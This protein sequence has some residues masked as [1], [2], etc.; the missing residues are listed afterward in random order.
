MIYKY[1]FNAFIIKALGEKSTFQS[2]QSFALF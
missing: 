2:M 1:K